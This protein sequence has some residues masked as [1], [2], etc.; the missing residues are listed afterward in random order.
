[1]INPRVSQDNR[2]AWDNLIWFGLLL[3]MAA[4]LSAVGVIPHLARQMGAAI[5]QRSGSWVAAFCALNVGERIG[6]LVMRYQ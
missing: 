6:W 5:T 2:P 1:M 4:H 3:G